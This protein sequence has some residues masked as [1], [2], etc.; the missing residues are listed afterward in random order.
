MLADYTCTIKNRAIGISFAVDFGFS[1]RLQ[2]NWWN[3]DPCS[4]PADEL[5]RR[6]TAK[7]ECRGC[8]RKTPVSS[9]AGRE[10]MKVTKGFLVETGIR[11]WKP[12][13]ACLARHAGQTCQEQ[14][15]GG[16]S[17]HALR[18]SACV[19]TPVRTRQE[20]LVL[21]PSGLPATGYR[22]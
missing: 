5:K 10:L 16:R 4:H 1:C 6:R 8:C 11:E 19:A 17:N 2:L 21:C 13:A 15:A 22:C 3:A 9:P 18:A 14:T 7:S 20:T 12:L